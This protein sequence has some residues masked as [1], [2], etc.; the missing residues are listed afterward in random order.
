MSPTAATAGIFGPAL[1][2]LAIWLT[3]SM[4]PAVLSLVVFFALGAL[5]LFGAVAMAWFYPLTREKHARV[6]SMLE[7]KK[8]RANTKEDV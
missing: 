5:L 3:G 7:R 8:E 2:T 1:F 4:Q 6:R